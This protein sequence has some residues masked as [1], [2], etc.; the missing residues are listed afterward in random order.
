MGKKRRGKRLGRTDETK[1]LIVWRRNKKTGSKTGEIKKRETEANRRNQEMG[2]KAEEN[3]HNTMRGE[4]P[5]IL[6][7]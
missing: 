3:V 4:K 6:K 5:M 2:S 1:A 7:K